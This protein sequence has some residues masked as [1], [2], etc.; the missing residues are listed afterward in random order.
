MS[1]TYYNIIFFLVAINLFANEL[2]GY[3]SNDSWIELQS[4]EKH[5]W[6]GYIEKPNINWVRTSSILPFTFEKVSKMIEKEENYS[7]IFNRVIISEEVLKDVIYMKIDMPF[8]FY[9]RD[10]LVE[11]S[12]VKEDS[13]ASYAFTAI[14]DKRYPP[15]SNC[16]RLENAAGEW[17]LERIDESSTRVNYTWNGD[18]GPSFP[19]YALTTAWKTQGSE[20]ITDLEKSLEK[21]YK[22]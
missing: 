9:D 12:I 18:Q 5:I 6:V 16:V 22:D 11:Y 2:P 14:E 21:L 4:G 13:A 19:S 10:Y 20:M 1:S 8:P 15:L 7:K 3:N 17:Y